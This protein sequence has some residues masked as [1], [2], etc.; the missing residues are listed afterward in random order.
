MS[1]FRSNLTSSRRK[2][3][4]SANPGW[5]KMTEKKSK[6]SFRSLNQ[7]RKRNNPQRKSAR[8]TSMTRQQELST[9]GSTILKRSSLSM[10]VAAGCNKSCYKT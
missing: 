9:E 1:L 6:Q 2:K 7:Q 3:Q 10:E 4:I 8:S 5:I